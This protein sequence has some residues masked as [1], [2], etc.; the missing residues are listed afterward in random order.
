MEPSNTRRLT[1]AWLVLVAITI[2]YVGIDGTAEDGGAH[3]ASTSVSVVAIGLGL[4]KFRVIV[5]EFMDV[6]HAPVLMR[7]LTDLLALV[8]AGALLASYAAGK[9]TS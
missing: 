3:T 4:V 7:R 2:V 5:R 9:A 8:I 1:G 6:R